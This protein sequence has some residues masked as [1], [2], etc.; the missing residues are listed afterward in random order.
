MATRPGTDTGETGMSHTATWDFL[1]LGRI[2]LVSRLTHLPFISSPFYN[3]GG[4][5]KAGRMESPH[6]HPAFQLRAPREVSSLYKNTASGLH[7]PMGRWDWPGNLQILQCG[8]SGVEV[9]GFPQDLCAQLAVAGKDERAVSAPSQPG[10]GV[11]SPSSPNLASVRRC[12]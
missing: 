7:L 12:I 8:V 3:R 1:S 4:G 11:I 2:R 5:Y 10:P 9:P 6:T